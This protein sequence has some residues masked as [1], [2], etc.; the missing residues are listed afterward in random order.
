MEIKLIASDMDDTLLNK[1]CQISPRNEAAIRKALDA[2]KIFLI[3]TG[4]M[5][6]SV[7]PYAQKLGL[8]VPLVTYNGALVKGSLS[9]KVYYE[10]KMKL[11]TPTRY[12]RTAARRAITCSFMWVTVF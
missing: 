7:R 8:D 12:W 4:R 9:G 1:D 2:G 10:H 11:P 6:V 3:A 5:Y